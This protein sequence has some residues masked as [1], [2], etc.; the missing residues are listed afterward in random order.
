MLKKE[1]RL[2]LLQL[3][4]QGWSR[5]Q[6]A[7]ALGI[8][9]GALRRAIPSPPRPPAQRLRASLPTSYRDR[10]VARTLGPRMPE[11][12]PTRARRPALWPRARNEL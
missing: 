9:P 10:R 5:H 8:A 1:A 7:R 2:V 6:I 3:F 11:S 12:W 4:R